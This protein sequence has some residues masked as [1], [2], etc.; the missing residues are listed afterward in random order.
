MK[1]VQEDGKVYLNL[2]WTALGFVLLVVLVGVVSLGMWGLPK[3]GVYQK[4]LNGTAKLAEA[5][6]D[7][8]IRIQEAKAKLEAAAMEAESE[9]TRAKGVAEANKIIG[10]SLKEN[11]E[12]LRWRFITML[13]ESGQ[14]GT[15]IIYIPTE[16][17][18]PVLEANR[19]DENARTGAMKAVPK[20]ATSA[21]AVTPK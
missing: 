14:F 12:Y 1:V 21:N 16:G 19:F 4:R 5:E 15:Q 6:Q 18:M 17:C 9:V 11:E 3:Y 10:E 7:R 13:E 2:S 20:E 8:Q